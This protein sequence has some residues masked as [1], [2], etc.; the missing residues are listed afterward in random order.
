MS[1]RCLPGDSGIA[2]AQTATAPRGP[3]GLWEGWFDLIDRN[4]A[5][6]PD[7][8]TP[9]VTSSPRLSNGFRFDELFEHKA[10][11]LTLANYG[12]GKGLQM[13]VFDKTELDLDAPPYEVES[14]AKTAMRGFGDWPSFNLKYRFL[15]ATEAHGDYVVSGYLQTVSPTGASSLSNHATMIS[16]GIAAGKGWGDFNVQANA[17]AAFPLRNQARLGDATIANIAAEY[18][19]GSYLWPELELNETYWPNG[20]KAGENQLYVTSGIQLGRIPLYDRLKLQL[21]IGYRYAPGAAKAGD[22][23]GWIV[24][25]RLVW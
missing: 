14:G 17:G 20:G 9:L 25:M 8:L 6:E 24:S 23:H 18:R 19:I 15:S 16:P 4:R 7:W 2:V 5:E 3:S 11:G 21:G 22:E 13:I 1:V 10:G 12:N